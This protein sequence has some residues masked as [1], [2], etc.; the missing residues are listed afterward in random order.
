MLVA[1]AM[2]DQDAEGSHDHDHGDT[3]AMVDGDH[4]ADGDHGEG[5]GSGHDDAH[6]SGHGDEGVPPLLQFDLGSAIC[7]LA[8]FIGVFA[9][10]AKFVWPPIL[11]GLRAREEKIHGDLIRA[12]RANEEAKAMLADY[13][14]KLGDAQ[15]EV[16]AMLAESRKD[17]E[18]SAAKIAEQAKQDADRQR[19]RAMADIEA[20]KKI[21]L[22]DLADQTSSMAIGVA[23]QVIGRELRPEDHAELIRSSLD[24]LPSQN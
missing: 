1:P 6:G 4:G 23:S 7:N 8:I 9:I 2:A 24:R 13:Q 12:E 15:A 17:A 5:H 21:A 11:E 16:Q 19:E 18:A 20:A 14:A 3:V 10:L 22:A